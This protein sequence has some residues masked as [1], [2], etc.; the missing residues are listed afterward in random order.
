MADKISHEIES[1]LGMDLQK[2]ALDVY[3]SFVSNLAL[4]SFLKKEKKD[5]DKIIFIDLTKKGDLP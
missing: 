2:A 1:I 3:K 4:P 5:H